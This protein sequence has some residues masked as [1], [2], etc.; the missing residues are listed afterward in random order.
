MDSDKKKFSFKPK[1]IGGKIEWRMNGT[2]WLPCKGVSAKTLNR[3]E[4]DS[5]GLIYIRSCQELGEQAA[6]NVLNSYVLSTCR[7][8][9]HHGSKVRPVVSHG[10]FIVTS[11]PNGELIQALKFWRRLIR[12]HM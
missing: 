6:C 2:S 11:V 9:V 7:T 8:A 4:I 12:L 3:W 1:D 5:K 10:M